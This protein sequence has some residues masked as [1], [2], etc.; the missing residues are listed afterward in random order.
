MI[1]VWCDGLWELTSSGD[2]I[3]TYGWVAYRKGKKLS[4]DCG[5]ADRGYAATN[6]VAEYT[7]VI[8]ALEWL[9]ENGYT[10][11]EIGVHS[12]SMLAMAQLS[13]EWQVR[14]PRIM[15]LYRQASVLASQFKRV[16]FWWVP[17]DR[18]QEADRLSR[19]A[20]ENITGEKPPE[21]QKRQRRGRR[22]RKWRW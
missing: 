7:A 12:D 20:Y 18:N 8:R 5:L 3:A 2:S 9:L 17:R 15:P 16:S 11:E 22:R 19:M 10:G 6:N 13:G 1:E 21:P 4:E 14:S